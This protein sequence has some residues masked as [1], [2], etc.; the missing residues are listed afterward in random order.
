MFGKPF[1]RHGDAANTSTMSRV[2]E[3]DTFAT[4]LQ[5]KNHKQCDLL[6]AK[7]ANQ[8]K[9]PCDVAL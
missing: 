4:A 2:N 3:R 8:S 1:H 9:W 7:G 6:N 5:E